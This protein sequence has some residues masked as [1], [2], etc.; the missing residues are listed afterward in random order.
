MPSPTFYYFWYEQNSKIENLFTL[1]DDILSD[2]LY[3]RLAVL[4]DDSPHPPEEFDPFLTVGK[5]C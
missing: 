3:L 4:P 2:L 5:Y 1:L